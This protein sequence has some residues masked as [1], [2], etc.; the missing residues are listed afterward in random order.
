MPSHPFRTEQVGELIK[1]E[2]GSLL[3]REI[4]F[5]TG[6]LVTVTRVVVTK[7]MRE[8]KAYISILPFA[9]RFVVL[10]KLKKNMYDIQGELNNNLQMKF[11][12]RLQFVIDATEEKAAIIDQLLDDKAN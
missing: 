11:A 5:P 2:L 9:R 12:P 4:D 7:D 8:A 3:L 6:T 10:E 1:Q